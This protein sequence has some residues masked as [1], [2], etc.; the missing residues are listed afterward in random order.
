MNVQE[1]VTR[2][3]DESSSRNW[4]PDRDINRLFLR[5]MQSYLNDKLKWQ[6]HLFL[7]EVYDELG[8][9]R[10]S[11]GAI[12]GWFKGP[13][14]FWNRELESDEEGAIT[15]VFITEGVIYDKIEES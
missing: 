13:I 8:L 9:S 15:L 1:T 4:S 7:N 5:N 11:Q 6:G 2:K 10:T 12:S 14:K 3:Y